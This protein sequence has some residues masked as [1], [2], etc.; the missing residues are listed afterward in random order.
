MGLAGPAAYALETASTAHSGSIPS[1]GPTVGS[2]FGGPGGFGGGP[3]RGGA[4]RFGGAPGGLAGGSTTQSRGGGFPPGFRTGGPGGAAGR[5][6]G[7]GGARGAP[8]GGAGSLLNGS[9]PDAALV[10]LLSAD[11]ADYTWVAA[12]VGS[13]SASGYQLSTND[14]VMAIGGFNGTDPVPTLAQFESYVKAGKVHYFIAGGG[15]V[16][17]GGGNSSTDDASKITTW[18]ANHFTAKTVGGETVYDLT[19]PS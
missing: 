5:P 3:G 19:A 17:G 18:V 2:G 16:G 8:N 6:T 1:A 11:A 9:T 7:V 15:R 4:A 10:K 14:P 12:T 13:D